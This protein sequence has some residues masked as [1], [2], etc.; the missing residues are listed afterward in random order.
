MSAIV[1]P[2]CNKPD[3]LWEEV[4]VP[5]WQSCDAYID[6]DGRRRTKAARRGHP[7]REVDWHAGVVSEHDM[8]CSHCYWEG[9][10]DELVQLGI[11]G[12]PLPVVHPG[13]ET[14]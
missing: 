8:G 4:M 9:T 10:R 5:G 13:Q 2:G 3:G 6:S 1:C 7:A 11:D 12:K 14:L